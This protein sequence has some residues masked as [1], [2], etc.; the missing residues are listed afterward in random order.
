MIGCLVPQDWLLTKIVTLGVELR[1]VLWIRKFLV[2]R[3]QTV[4]VRGQLSEEVTVTSVVP[5]G[6]VLGPLLFLAH[7]NDIWKNTGSA[8]RLFADGCVIYREIVNNNDIERL[9]TYLG[10]LGEWAVENG[11]KMNSGKSKAISF[12]TAQVN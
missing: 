2:G 8:I 7:I 1:V 9:Q 3:I 12:T 10:R 5:Q 6:S 11:M 4:R